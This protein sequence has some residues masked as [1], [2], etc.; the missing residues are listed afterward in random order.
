METDGNVWASPTSCCGIIHT[1]YDNI[2]I[3]VR[4]THATC[5]LMVWALVKPYDGSPLTCKHYIGS[6]EV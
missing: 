6:S 4:N 2:R 5:R 3:C 1:Y